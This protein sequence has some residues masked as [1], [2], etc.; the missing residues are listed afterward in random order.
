MTVLPENKSPLKYGLFAI[1]IIFI[2]LIFILLALSYMQTHKQRINDAILHTKLVE[3]T[4]SRTLEALEV[5]LNSLALDVA[6]GRFEIKHVYDLS[7]KA[8]KILNFSP[9]L[10]QITLVHNNQTI[11]DTRHTPPEDINVNILELKKNRGEFLAEGI[12]IGSVIRGRYLPLRNRGA[13]EGSKR[14]LLPVSFETYNINGEEALI[15]AAFNPSYLNSFILGLDSTPNDSVYIIDQDGDTIIQKGLYGPHRQKI[16]ELHDSLLSSGAQE[17]SWSSS[18]ILLGHSYALRLSSQ[19]SFAAISV[20]S[21]NDTFMLWIDERSVQ[22]LLL[23]CAM[24]FLLVTSYLTYKSNKKALYMADEVHLLSE[25]VEHN[26]TLIFITNRKGVIHYANKSFEVYSGYRREQAIG[27]KPSILKSGETST[28]T[29]KDLWNK[30]T[31]GQEWQGELHNKDRNGNSFWVRANISPLLN[32]SGDISHFIA[33]EQVITEEKAI[34]EKVRLASTVFSS[35][36]EGIMVT[37]IDNNIQLVNNAFETITGYHPSEVLGRNPKLLKSGKHT[38]D[39]YSELYLTLNEKGSWSG[40]IWNK[41]KTGQIYPQ[42]LTISERRDEQGRLE[43]YVSLFSDISKRKHDEELIAHQA[44]FD[45]LTGLPNRH[46]FKDRLEMALKESDRKRCTS[47]LLFIDLDRFKFVNDN[48]GHSTGDLLLKQVA[49]RLQTS[50]R[51][52]DTVARLGGDEFAV[53]IC[54]VQSPRTI[55]LIAR[56]ILLTI[57]KPFHLDEHVAYISCSIG[58]ANYPSNANDVEEILNQADTAMYKAK[59]K[60]KNTHEYFSDDLSADLHRKAELEKEIHKSIQ[61]HDFYMVYQP[62][63]NQDGIQTIAYEALVRWNHPEKG[64]ISPKEFIR[65]AE[66]TGQILPL[67]EIIIDQACIF[68]RN[69]NELQNNPPK[70]SINISPVQ[71]ARGDVDQTIRKA[72]SKNRISGKNI[73][74]EIT[75]SVL[76]END[77]TSIDQLNTLVE[78]GIEIAIDDFGTGYSSLSY[79]EKFP[80]SR[81]KIDRSFTHAMSDSKRHRAIVEAIISMAE[82][83]DLT[84]I[85]EGVETEKQLAILRQHSGI[86][87]QGFIFSQAKSPQTFL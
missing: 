6:K 52:T 5:S 20:V 15:V 19:Y 30:I 48:Y 35:S 24:F 61:H 21:F 73:I 43:G 1:N 46:L 56:K 40:E 68:A 62:I 63:M 83:L 13:D 26:P 55:E 65:V 86:Q 11:V 34:Q 85:A 60:G 47:T 14:G 25:V 32:S 54:E 67:G 87:I 23:L 38:H 82:A 31:L 17:L 16:I 50:V 41:R 33:V 78:L 79:L 45:G 9:Q 77:S 69:L 75:E 51:A 66:E 74:I 12:N 58:I 39:F 76:L 10:R 80:I 81:L 27:K 84:V 70:V 7:T 2:A 36:T 64:E 29:Y 42:W 44:N 37:D 72:L 4:F 8:H 3:S 71:L 53:I 57:E 28:E 59:A 49:D 18:N 22:L